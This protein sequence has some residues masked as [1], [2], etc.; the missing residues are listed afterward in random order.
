LIEI[1]ES[2]KNSKF[3]KG[4]IVHI[5]EIP[6]KQPKYKNPTEI[7]KI[8]KDILDRLGLKLYTHQADALDA[9]LNGK[10]VFI[11][12]STGSGKTLIYIL[13]IIESLLRNKDSKALVLYPTKALSN[14]QLN[15]FRNFE[16]LLSHTQILMNTNIF[17]GDTSK[18]RERIEQTNV[19]LSNPYAFHEYLQYHDKWKSMYKN[20]K[21]IIIDE[22]HHY[23]GIF[24]SNVAM[25]IRRLLRLCKRYGSS[26]QLIL[27][28]AT[29][30][31]SLEFAEKLTGRPFVLIDNDGSDKSRKYF[32]FW[33]SKVSEEI[34]LTIQ[35][36]NLVVFFMNKRVQLLC[37]TISR[38][39][40]ELVS[41]FVKNI[42][43]DNFPTLLPMISP[44][45]AGYLPETRREIERQLREK[46]LL[47]VISTNALELGIDIGNLDVVIIGN[48][49]GTI[50][51]TWQQAGRAGRRD[52]ESI[53]IL[54]A[55]RDPLEQ[56]L[57]GH[58]DEFFSKTP[59]NAIISLTNEYILAGHIMCAANEKILKE[60]EIK[61]F[62]GDLG[63]EIAK[64]MA[65]E[66]IINKTPAGYIYFQGR[67]PTEYVRLNNIGG[68]LIKILCDNKLLEIVDYIYLYREAYP[69]AVFLHQAE[70]YIVEN[71][72]LN[73]NIVEVIKKDVDY[74]TIPLNI[75]DIEIRNTIEMRE[76]NTIKISFGEVKVTDYYQRYRIEK[77]GK[78]VGYGLIDLP[79]LEFET[80]AVWFEIPED[81]IASIES[82]KELDLSGG[83]HGLEHAMIAMAPLI[84][85]CDRWDIGGM[86]TKYHKA[87]QTATIFIY[88]A[89]PGGIGISEKLYEKFWELIEKTKTM[90]N[91]CKCTN[92]CPSCIMSP[93]C[94]NEN[95]PL[96]KKCTIFLANRLSNK[97]IQK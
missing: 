69:E 61:E 57:I 54:C 44:Y 52:K 80:Q 17:D 16:N 40:A 7:S 89:F 9:V 47:A 34:P 13:A 2:L 84:A 15:A 95:S 20:L 6:P 53:V 77:R 1:I 18:A 36:S 59:E 24:G 42:L 64:R 14:D 26:P 37:F 35:L 86:S 3:Y 10:N 94:G 60:E 96:N 50:I 8:V 25:L 48:Y 73:N 82:N 46:N 79:P 19:F 91:E 70:T 71:V 49:P 68:K 93:K 11:T 29:I 30:S 65:D 58:P 74:Y 4:Q 78:K 41:S 33:N 76:D 75:T 55:G 92:G 5:R 12:T 67:R 62:F 85:M 32:V 38:K 28:S 63:L 51:S 23:R 81:L 45:R 21:Y 43:K 31:N 87:T 66:K 72:D 90:L 56:Y 22:A 97:K 83:L 39:T 88:D 27:C